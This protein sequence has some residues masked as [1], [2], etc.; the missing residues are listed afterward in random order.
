MGVS[1][2]VIDSECPYCRRLFCA[3]CNV[4]WYDGLACK[5]FQHLGRSINRRKGDVMLMGIA[6]NKKW[7]RC[8]KCKCY[9]EK[10]VGYLQLTCWYFSHSLIFLSL[11]RR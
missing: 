6:K 5:D 7:R 1:D 4:S 9:V 3:Q 11:N 10:S 2:N 8:S